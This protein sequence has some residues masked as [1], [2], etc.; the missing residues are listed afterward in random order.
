ML[1]GIIAGIVGGN[2]V[3]GDVILVEHVLSTEA[4]IA[5]RFAELNLERTIQN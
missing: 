1:N 4:I 2:G 3:G 5:W